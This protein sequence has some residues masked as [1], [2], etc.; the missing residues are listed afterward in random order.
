LGSDVEKRRVI[1]TALPP[2]QL[3]MHYGRLRH[4]GLRIASGKLYLLVGFVYH[5]EDCAYN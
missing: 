3:L 1:L 4:E 5:R 2:A